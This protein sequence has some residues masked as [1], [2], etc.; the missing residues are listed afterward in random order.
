MVMSVNTYQRSGNTFSPTT[1]RALGSD[2]TCHTKRVT[3][4]NQTHPQMASQAMINGQQKS[5]K[6]RR[7]TMM[8][9]KSPVPMLT[10][11]VWMPQISSRVPTQ[12]TLLLVQILACHPTSLGV[13]YQRDGT[14]RPH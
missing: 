3:V 2:P 9:M 1:K 4:G 7:R 14:V 5:L 10:R 6:R 8:M 11:L 13:D 12:V